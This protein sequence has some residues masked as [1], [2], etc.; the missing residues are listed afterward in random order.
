MHP[1]MGYKINYMPETSTFYDQT[2]AKG[3]IKKTYVPSSPKLQNAP[4]IINSIIDG[5]HQDFMYTEKIRG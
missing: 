3:T 4:W 5:M 2:V 1:L